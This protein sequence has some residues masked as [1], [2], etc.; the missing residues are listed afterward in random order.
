MLHKRK[1]FQK[2]YSKETLA[3]TINLCRLCHR[4]IHALFDETILAQQ[5]DTLEKLKAHPQ[6]AK[7]CAWVA[8]Q[9]QL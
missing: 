1:R 3:L 4:G 2:H 9:K 7:H 6:V 8:K 5:L